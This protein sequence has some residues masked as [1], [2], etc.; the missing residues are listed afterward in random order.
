[1]LDLALTNRAQPDEIG[2][3]G[4]SGA[5]VHRQPGILLELDDF[6][7]PGI[8]VSRASDRT[9]SRFA[10]QAGRGGGSRAGHARFASSVARAGSQD[11]KL[12]G[13]IEI[14]VRNL[15]CALTGLPCSSRA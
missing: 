9:R 15:A 14:A 12:L 2:L 6:R 3:A 4:R 8:E 5:G 11:C 13:S 7:A 10:L 1:M